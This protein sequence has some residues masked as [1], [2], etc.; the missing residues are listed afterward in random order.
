[1]NFC[2]HPHQSLWG[3]GH[4]KE[5]IMEARER[6]LAVIHHERPDR[7]PCDFWGTPEVVEGLKRHLGTEEDVELWKSLGIDKILNLTPQRHLGTSLTLLCWS[8][9]SR[10]PGYLGGQV[11]AY[12]LPQWESDLLGGERASTCSF[13]HCRGGAGFLYLS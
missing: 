10:R 11:P 6:I 8:S 2:P 1:M 9:P 13:E 5:I 7:I 4:D 12:N 3:W